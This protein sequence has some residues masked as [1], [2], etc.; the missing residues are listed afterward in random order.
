MSYDMGDFDEETS[1]GFGSY[2][3]TVT[4]AGV[5]QGKY[6]PQMVIGCQPTNPQRRPQTLFMSMGKGKFIFGGDS[7][8]IITGDGDNAFETL[9]QKEIVEGPK[10][11]VVTKAGLFL[12]ALKHL[13]FV[14]TGGDMS[15]YVGLKVDLEEIKSTEAIRRFNKIHPDNM[16][17]AFGKEYNITI[18][19]KIISM[20]VKTVTLR[21][22]ALEVIEG[23]SEAEMEAWYKGTERY[24]GSVT[25]LYKML[26][27]LE[28]TDVLIINDKYMLKKETGK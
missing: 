1:G 8:K 7:E 16:L 24:D 20:P 11:K 25:A 21:E 4:K 2:E 13:G 19:T 27:V 3:A 26:A 12:N 22:A 18:P 10:I 14:V 28:K 6:G 15:V 9:V 17:E 5:A 23:K